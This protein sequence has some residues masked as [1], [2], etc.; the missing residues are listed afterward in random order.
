MRRYLNKTIR[1][2]AG[3]F[4]IS[5][6]RVALFALGGVR[7]GRRA[8]I[9][10]KVRIG[11]GTSIGDS[12]RIGAGAAIGRNVLIGNH[13]KIGHAAQIGDGTRIGDNVVISELALVGNAV[14][15]RGSFIE[16]GV[17]MTGFQN[18]KISIGDHTY[19]GI[20]AVLD[21]SGGIE[22]GSHVHVAGPSVGIWTHSSILQALKGKEIDDRSETF[23]LPVRI[24]DNV[25]IGGNSTLYP[26][27]TVGPLAVVLPNSVVNRDVSPNTVAGGI[28]ATVKRKIEREGLTIRLVKPGER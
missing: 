28:P 5:R 23:V 13:S 24:N 3:H 15:G 1:F 10:Y 26:G 9:G 16:R 20:G 25:W 8:A 11:E 27:T 14:I 4:P 6:V 17:I 7:T 19:I 21:W 18:G 2:A 22:I 12:A